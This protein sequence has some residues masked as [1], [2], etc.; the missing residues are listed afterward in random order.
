MVIAETA[1]G[2]S[3]NDIRL[4]GD[5]VLT[6]AFRR[7][8]PGSL[9]TDNWLNIFIWTHNIIIQNGRWSRAKYRDSSKVMVHH[10][11]INL[12]MLQKFPKRPVY[13]ILDVCEYFYQRRL[14]HSPTRVT[15]KNAQP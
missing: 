11:Y 7:F 13:C 6:A 8:L 15:V 4:S 5:S 9:S 1:D 14:L 2:Q 12:L 10:R 3:C